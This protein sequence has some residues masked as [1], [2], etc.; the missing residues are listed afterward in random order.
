[1]KATQ[2]QIDAAD[3]LAVSTQEE[4]TTKMLRQIYQL[5]L[6]DNDLV[7]AYRKLAEIE[8]AEDTSDPTVR[9]KQKDYAVSQLADGEAAI[10]KREEACFGQLEQSLRQH[11]LQS[12]PACSEWIG[13]AKISHADN[14]GARSAAS[15]AGDPG[16]SANAKL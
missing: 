1:M 15:D 14:D 4:S 8:G 16:K 11:T 3:G 10:Q 5:K 13:K 9:R 6:Q 2:S 12:I 7:R